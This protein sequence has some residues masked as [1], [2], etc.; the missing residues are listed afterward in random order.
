MT[1]P[2]IAGADDASDTEVGRYEKAFLATRRSLDESIRNLSVLQEFEEDTDRKDQLGETIIKL[3]G[4]RS[5]LVRANVAF[6]SHTATMVPP[7]PQQV[8]E[9][10]DLADQ[11]T[12][13][14]QQRATAAASLKLATSALNKFAKIQQLA[15]DGPGN[16]G[17]GISQ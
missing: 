16:S 4:S 3:E 7:S 8:A 12:Q 13:L 5:D 10:I 6:H 1:E 15:A 14:T 11:A 17:A 9:L 2:N